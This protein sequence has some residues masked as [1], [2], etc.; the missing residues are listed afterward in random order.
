M[1]TPTNDDAVAQAVTEYESAMLSFLDNPSMEGAK[2][3]RVADANCCRLGGN[4]QYP[5]GRPAGVE[6]DTCTKHT[7]GI[8][9]NW[10]RTTSPGE[11]PCRVHVAVCSNKLVH[12]L[13]SV[14]APVGSELWHITEAFRDV[15]SIARRAY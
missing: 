10:L 1:N 6:T 14:H 3:W 11:V 4:E 12:V 15:L 9:I 7:S 13:N 2:R 5:T 8:M